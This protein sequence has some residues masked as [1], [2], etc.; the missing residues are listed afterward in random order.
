M[1][2]CHITEVYEESALHWC[3]LCL[4]TAANVK[5]PRVADWP[6]GSKPLVDNTHGSTSCTALH[7]PHIYGSADHCCHHQSQRA[8]AQGQ[9]CIYV[10][11]Q[12]TIQVGT[13][14]VKLNAFTKCKLFLWL[15][16][17]Q[18]TFLVASWPFC[19]CISSFCHLTGNLP[20]SIPCPCVSLRKGVAITWT[21]WLCPSCWAFA[22][23][24]DCRGLS[25]Q[26]SSPSLT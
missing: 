20:V 18:D 15:S 2:L 1:S 3:I 8:Q 11:L 23:W 22:Q 24:W 16:C 10:R 17:Q 21:C 6:A 25:P 14:A 7:H 13:P 26:R 19:S 4:G 12:C 9:L 5:E